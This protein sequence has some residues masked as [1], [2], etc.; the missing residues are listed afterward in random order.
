MSSSATQEGLTRLS[1]LDRLLDDDPSVS[2]EVPLNKVQRARK[3]QEAIRRD[4]QDLLN[5]RYR[6]LAWP[7]Q[8]DQLEG[9]LVNYGI[10]D[11][12]AAGLDVASD[13]ETML[14]AVEDSIKTYEPRLTDVRVT[15]AGGGHYDRIL[16]FRI[17]ATL[18]LENERLPLDY[19]T[20]MESSTGK[21]EV[22]D[23]F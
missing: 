1:L 13:E 15:S 21:F 7:P 3:A 12:T 2:E 17:Q 4:L 16:R 10:P 23:K 22:G 9:S 5:T 8:L 20:R 14:S 19:K 6:C 18:L 11:F